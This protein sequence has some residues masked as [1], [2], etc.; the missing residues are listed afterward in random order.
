MRGGCMNKFCHIEIPAPEME[1]TVKFYIEV[2]GWE[3]ELFPD[4]TYAMFKDGA[5]GG[6]FDPTL[7]IQKDGVN[8]ILEVD[9]IPAKLEEIVE[10]GGKIV[11][12]K[13]EIGEGYGFYASF[14]D[15]N[16]N[17]LSIWS[18]E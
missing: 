7:S 15:V 1:K 5:V 18:K 16:G 3:V 12:E 11:K 10:A 6:G 4:K 17:R 14:L 2:F 8:L 13:T 9:D